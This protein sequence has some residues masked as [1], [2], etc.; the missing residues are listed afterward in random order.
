MHFAANVG[1]YVQF[2]LDIFCLLTYPTVSTG[3]VSRHEGPDQPALLCRL[4]RA[5]VVD[6]LHRAII[7][8]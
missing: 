6:K 3:P 7:L 4:V 5:C 2:N 8:R 1:T